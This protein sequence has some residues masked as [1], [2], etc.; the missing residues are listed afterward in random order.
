MWNCGLLISRRLLLLCASIPL[1]HLTLPQWA[2]AIAAAHAGADTTLLPRAMV[3]QMLTVQKG[4][5]GIGP[6]VE[7]S[8]RSFRFGHGGANEGYR[9][10]VTYYPEAGVGLAVMTNSDVGDDVYQELQFAIAEEYDWPDFGPKKIRE[11]VRDSAAL[12]TYVGKYIISFNS[13]T[14]P[15]DVDYKGGKLS[16]TFAGAPE[17]EEL[18]PADSIGGFHGIRRGWEIRFTGDSLKVIL[19]SDTVI[20]GRRK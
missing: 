13:Q 5:F 2:L 15:F 14:Y 19:D 17:G 7:G 10:N 11:V 18:V 16:Y 6:S 20:P 1:P 8:G 4:S 3:D 9:A 12:A